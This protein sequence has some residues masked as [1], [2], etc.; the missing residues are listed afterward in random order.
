MKPNWYI[1]ASSPLVL[2]FIRIIITLRMSCF[3][4][5]LTVSIVLRLAQ[6]PGDFG[7][8]MTIELHIWWLISLRT[9][10]LFAVSEIQISI[11]FRTLPMELDNPPKLFL[12]LRWSLSVL[13]QYIPSFVPLFCSSVCSTFISCFYRS[14]YSFRLFFICCFFSNDTYPSF[15]LV[16]P[17][18]L[19]LSFLE[20]LLFSR[21]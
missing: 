17:D 11:M 5:C 12:S 6:F 14:T 15:P 16:E 7:R 4:I 18:F 20:F 2:R 13:F 3:V 1:G 19:I 8:A 10:M 21:T 9:Y